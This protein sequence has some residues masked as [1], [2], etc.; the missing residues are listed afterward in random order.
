MKFTRKVLIIICTTSI[1]AILMILLATLAAVTWILPKDYSPEFPVQN[2]TLSPETEFKLNSDSLVARGHYLVYGPGHCADC[3]ARE[4]DMD[5]VSKGQEV[6]LAGGHRLKIYLGEIMHPNLTPDSLT[7]I[8][9]FSDAQ[10]RR[11]FRTS[12]TAHGEVGLPMMMMADLSESDLEAIITFLRSQ[13]PVRNFVPRTQFNFLG[14]ITQAFFLEPFA[15]SLPLPQFD[16][17]DTS[18]AYGSYLANTVANCRACHTARNMKTGEFEG[19]PFAGGLR[20]ARRDPPGVI[21]VSPNLTPD[22][23]T[24]VITHFTE[25]AFIA[26]FKAGLVAPWSPM[27]WGPFSRMT[28]HDLAALYRYLKSLEPQYRDNGPS[29]QV[30][31][32]D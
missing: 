2:Y 25:E 23:T 3:H 30:I 9:R 26:R 6:P 19:P 4:K 17:P 13:K 11:F 1:T 29:F 22:S 10:L 20:I 14:Q 5:A 27:P 12:I 8:G 21:A 24:G 28:H 15:P 32:N 7:G 16:K 18:V 31:E